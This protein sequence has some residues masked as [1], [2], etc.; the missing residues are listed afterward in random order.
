M[1]VS[2]GE[3]MSMSELPPEDRE[4]LFNSMKG[5]GWLGWIFPIVFGIL[6][7]MIVDRCFQAI[8]DTFDDTIE[9]SAP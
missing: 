4:R 1:I 9:P 8:Q 7:A 5:V 6:S 2:R 3:I